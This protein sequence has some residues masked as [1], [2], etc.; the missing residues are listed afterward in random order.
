[1]DEY[2]D[3]ESWKV[4]KFGKHAP[5]VA[6]PVHSPLLIYRCG[7]HLRNW[8]LRNSAS[9]FL[10]NKKLTIRTGAQFRGG[11]KNKKINAWGE[12]FILSVY[13]KNLA[14]RTELGDKNRT[15]R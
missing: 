11:N 10:K 9:N 7:H 4:G 5:A 3:V 6:T 14:I 12:S 1:M 8:Q 13:S 15:W 2:L